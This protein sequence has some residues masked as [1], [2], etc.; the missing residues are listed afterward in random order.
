MVVRS[1]PG[2]HVDQ[3]LHVGSALQWQ[4]SLLLVL[5]Q[6][7]AE[8]LSPLSCCLAEILVSN[9]M[10]IRSSFPF[11]TEYHWDLDDFW[12][13]ICNDNGFLILDY[14]YSDSLPQ[15]KSASSGFRHTQ[16]STGCSLPPAVDS[17]KLW[18]W[19]KQQYYWGRKRKKRWPSS[20]KHSFKMIQWKICCFVCEQCLKV[21]GGWKQK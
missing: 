16:L 21:W 6:G 11:L 1:V 5:V 3:L 10:A 2:A 8:G 9:K 19:I 7:F 15:I 12:S 13:R 14:L 17:P 18:D 4:L 20:G